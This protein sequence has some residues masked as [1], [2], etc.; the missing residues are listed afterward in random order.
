MSDLR[1]R[2]TKRDGTNNE[3]VTTTN[4]K[5]GST[6]ATHRDKGDS[7]NEHKFGAD[8]NADADTD[9]DKHL[10]IRLKKYLAK[11]RGKRRHS[12]V[13]LLGGLFG[14]F[15]ALFFANHNEVISLD[16]LMDLNI[17]SLIDAMP[18]AILRDAK[19]FT[20]GYF[21]HALL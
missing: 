5:A 21:S 19:E 20:V 7:T 10:I 8:E 2:A 18:S 1:R 16:S 13:F 6:T 12:F 9:A 14:I 11:P 15:V 17:D 4:G 3:A